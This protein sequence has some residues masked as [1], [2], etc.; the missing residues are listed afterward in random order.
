MLVRECLFVVVGVVVVAGVVVSTRDIQG[1]GEYRS[2]EEDDLS[3]KGI[4]NGGISRGYKW[5]LSEPKR[6][7]SEESRGAR[8]VHFRSQHAS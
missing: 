7:Q 2:V 8:R 1:R 4:V 3:W 6:V 5:Q